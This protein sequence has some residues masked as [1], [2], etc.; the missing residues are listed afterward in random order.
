[1]A[2][3]A[4]CIGS[5]L[6]RPSWRIPN[7]AT[8]LDEFKF[9]S[10][11]A[12]K[13]AKKNC[14]KGLCRAM[15][16]SSSSS[17]RHVIITGGNTGKATA[18]ELAR[19]GMAVTIACR[20]VE[21][22]KQ[23]VADI[24]RESSN[25][26]VRVM[27]LDLASFASI[28]QFAAGY[29]HLGLPLNS[30]VNNAG[31]MACPQQYT[32]DGFEYQLGVNHLGHF[33]LTSLLLGKL[34]SCASPGMKSRVVVLASAAERI[35]NIDFN[36]LNYKSRSYNNWLA[37]GQSKLANCLFSL[38]LSR[39]CTSLG[40]P[41]TSNSMH[42]GI[43]DTELIRYVFPQALDR[44]LPFS[45]LRPVVTKLLGL[46]T[47]KQGASTSVYLANSSEMEGL[48]GGYYEDSRKAN[49]SARATDTELSFK[50]W[51]VSEELTNTTDILEPLQLSARA[52]QG[53]SMISHRLTNFSS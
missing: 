37:Y 26:S 41:V 53:V 10:M 7:S 5:L 25:P 28:R 21:K 15:Q 14:R 11:L 9:Q 51:A 45:G 8:R 38:E 2:I 33:L 40:I 1:M 24:I 47:P 27:E 17:Q 32:V 36:D 34:K 49:P 39:R 48:T 18:T 20:N 6:P 44:S 31:V 13:V 46:K 50:L 3:A 43:V 30:L 12:R 29:L 16:S 4:T 23:A 42:P 35:G 22:G 19:Q 52:S